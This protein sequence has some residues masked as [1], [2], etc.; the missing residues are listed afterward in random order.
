[1][2][3]KKKFE[4][5]IDDFRKQMEDYKK[6]ND[7][8]DEL[9]KAHQKEL[10]AYIQEHNKKYSGL[11]K[12][13]LDSEDQLKD[14]FEKEKAQLIKDWEKKLKDAVEKARKEAKTEQ[15]KLKKD[16]DGKIEILEQKIRKLEG[17][18]SDL[19]K[20]LKDKD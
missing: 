10:A 9:K 8:I 17:E 13:K 1:M 2:D 6:N 12:E 11:L 4:S 15:E 16:Y 19:N 3:M 20:K 7:V 18:I 5:R 14:Q